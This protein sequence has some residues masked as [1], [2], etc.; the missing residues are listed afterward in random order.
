MEGWGQEKHLAVRK[1]VVKA[2]VQIAGVVGGEETGRTVLLGW[3]ALGWEIP[4]PAAPHP[5]R[6]G[7]C[8]CSCDLQG[9]REAGQT[10]HYSM[11]Y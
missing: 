3:G 9:G 6:R 2:K 10:S 11:L 1:C 5:G 8:Q 4:G 7:G